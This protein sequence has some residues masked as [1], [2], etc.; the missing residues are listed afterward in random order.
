MQS[1]AIYGQICGATRSQC[2]RELL[3]RKNMELED[4]SCVLCSSSTAESLFHLLID[5]DLPQPAGTGLECRLA[6]T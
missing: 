4:Y 1:P 5:S 2:T 6:N 3:K